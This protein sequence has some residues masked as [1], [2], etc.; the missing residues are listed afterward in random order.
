MVNRGGYSVQKKTMAIIKKGKFTSI[1]CILFVLSLCI[2]SATISTQASETTIVQITS[3]SQTVSAGQTFTVNVSCTPGQPIKSFELKVS[4]NPSLLQANS[5]IEGNI[6]HGYTT[7]FNAGII[8]NVAGTIINIYDL[9]IG[10]DLISS[11]G[12][13]VII[14]FTAKS[15]SGTSII[16]LYDVGITDESGYITS[17]ASDGNVTVLGENQPPEFSA[18]TPADGST[19]ISIGTS[20]LS[21][22]IQDPEG[23]AFNWSITT[24]PNVGS[25]TGINQHNGSKLCSI[26]GLSHSTTYDWIVSCK[27]IGSGQWT[28]SSFMFTTNT[29]SYGG[30]PSGGSGGSISPE[31]IQNIPPNSP[32]KPSGP[33]SIERGVVYSYTSAS[34][35]SDGNRVRLQFDWGDGTISDWSEFIPS[36]TSVAMSH[37]WENISTHEVRV[38]AQDNNGSNSSWSL[39]LTVTVSEVQN[40]E[41]PTIPTIQAPDNALVNQTIMFDASGSI[42]PNG[43]D[44][45]YLWNFGDGTTAAGKNPGHSYQKPGIYS[46]TLTLTDGMGKTYSK[47]FTVTITAGTNISIHGNNTAFPYWVIGLLLIV[48]V[49]IISIIYFLR[50]KPRTTPLQKSLTRMEKKIERLNIKMTDFTP[51]KEQIKKVTTHDVKHPHLNSTSDDKSLEKK[52]DEILL[53][54]IE[55]EIDKM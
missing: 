52:V 20:S 36:N 18:I 16:H 31:A 23:N 45:S 35:D 49:I 21:L 24:N 19:D 50:K 44:V 39:P 55:N 42:I 7:F 17:S 54:K 32:L 26:S 22:I 38:L 15:R 6:F 53:S 25:A 11:P 8:S 10:P 9:I 30:N 12:S 27:D 14:S 3:S 43:V 13:F 34:F 1:I 40:G 5:V 33:T 46:V 48:S 51:S 4:F 37:S 41:E 2:G 28:N 29:E 47:T